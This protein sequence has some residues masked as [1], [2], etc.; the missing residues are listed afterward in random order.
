MLS[1]EQILITTDGQG[2]IRA[3][4]KALNRIKSLAIHKG[5][6]EAYGIIIEMNDGR[7]CSASRQ[8]RNKIYDEVSK[9]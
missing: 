8:I 7:E 1:D 2:G 3:K 6:L 5:L 9:V 4:Q